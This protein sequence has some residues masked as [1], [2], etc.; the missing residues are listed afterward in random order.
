MARYGDHTNVHPLGN[1][2]L[3]QIVQEDEFQN[4]ASMLFE[5]NQA[6]L[7]AQPIFLGQLKTLIVSIG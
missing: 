4:L 5:G 6:L 7:H 2:F 3:G 1:L